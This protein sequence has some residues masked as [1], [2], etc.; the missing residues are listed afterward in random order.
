MGSNNSGLIPGINTGT[1]KIRRATKEGQKNV[2]IYLGPKNGWQSQVLGA[3]CKASGQSESS[4][5]RNLFLDYL[6]K[7]GV[8]DKETGKPDLEAVERI[9]EKSR[10]STLLPSL[11]E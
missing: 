9:K 3:I 1:R 6:A 8:Y 11:D 7:Y 5:F 10:E 4:F 2:S